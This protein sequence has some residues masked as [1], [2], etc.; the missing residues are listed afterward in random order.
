MLNL[1]STSSYANIAS[2]AVKSLSGSRSMENNNSLM[3]GS[4]SSN[5]GNS[6]NLSST[7]LMPA[8]TVTTISASSSVLAAAAGLNSY[9]KELNSLNYLTT[10]TLA[11]AFQQQQHQQ[12][13]LVN[14]LLPSNNNNNHNN[15]NTLTQSMGN[16]LS[17]SSNILS[18]VP[19]LNLGRRFF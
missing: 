3:I 14:K 19:N 2:N 9:A 1:T 4:T 7:N 18:S 5:C 12:Q 11:A 16:N 15:N 10:A 17:G 13:Q 8:T 6:L